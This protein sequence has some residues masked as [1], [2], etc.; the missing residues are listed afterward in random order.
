MKKRIFLIPVLASLLFACN[1]AAELTDSS[2]VNQADVDVLD[3][4]WYKVITVDSAPTMIGEGYDWSEGPLWLKD[5]QALLFSDVPQNIVYRWREGKGVDTFLF[6]SGFPDTSVHDWEM[7]S[8]GLTL[9]P[10]NRLVLCQHGNRQMAVMDAPLSA[11]ASSFKVIAASF[12]GKRFSSPND[13]VYN[14]EGELFFTDP[15]YGLPQRENDPTKETEWN[16]VYKVK[17]DGT[18]LLLT[19]SITRPNGIALTPDGTKLYIANS[20]PDKPNWYRYDIS[21]DSLINGIIWCTSTGRG[22]EWEGGPDGLK[23]DH[24]GIVYSSGPGGIWVINPAGKVL[25]RLRLKGAISNCALSD[26][27]KILYIT[28]DDKVWRWVMRP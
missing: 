23:V 12:D 16:G 15:P 7:G 6:P 27:E 14:S 4:N 21:G 2:L 13:A 9:D 17:K 18:V 22:S 28:N 25:G 8:N 5:Q 20:D 10:D 1:N 24:N 11:P 3:S 26:D 19:D